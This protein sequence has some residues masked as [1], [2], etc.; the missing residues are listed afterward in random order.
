MSR[1]TGRSRTVRVSS[2][3]LPDLP[4]AAAAPDVVP[5]GPVGVAALRA[6]AGLTANADIPG[7]DVPGAASS[8]AELAAAALRGDRHAWTA[9]IQRHDRRVVVSLLARGV[10]MERARELAQE[11]WLRLMEQQLR[12]RL[13]ALTLP[14]LAITQAHFLLLTESRRPAHTVPEASTGDPV[15]GHPSALDRL[16]GREQLARAE[17][18]LAGCSPTARRVF[19][20][21]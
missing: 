4:S 15:D 7:G 20:T 19:A 21:V 8:E 13:P 11:T 18:V 17:K 9:L 6:G 2:A 1:R 3:S 16:L 12:G 10:R 5:D 14:G